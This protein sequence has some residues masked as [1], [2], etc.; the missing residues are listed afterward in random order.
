MVAFED[1]LAQQA[2]PLT[3]VDAAESDRLAAVVARVGG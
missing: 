1:G 2:R 3:G